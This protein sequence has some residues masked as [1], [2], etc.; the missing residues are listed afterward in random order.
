M[1]E[2]RPGVGG[3][4]RADET[5]VTD[6]LLIPGGPG[7]S[8]FAWTLFLAGFATFA[9]LFAPQAFLSAQL[10]VDADS[11]SMTVSSTALGVAAG[12]LGWAA[13][14]N[15]TGHLR[16][17][18]LSLLVALLVAVVVPLLPDLQSVI[19]VR[20][21]EGLALGAAPAV[22]MAAIAERVDGRWVAHVAGTFVAGNTLGGIVGRLAS[23]AVADV[24]GWRLAFWVSAG[25]AAVA[26]GALLVLSRRLPD[27]RA[28]PA[29]HSAARAVGENLRDPVMLALYLQGF[30]LMGA[31]GAVYNFFGYRVQEPPFGLPA[32]IAGGL[33]LVY[34]TGSVA[35]Q[36]SGALARRIGTA[37]AMVAGIAAML[38]SLPMMA[39]DSLAA[40][41][42]GLV[43]F[44]IGCFTAHPLASGLSGRSA[45]IGRPQSAALYQIAWLGGTSLCGWAG[46]LAYAAAG[47]ATTLGLVAILC[48]VAAVAAVL[49][50]TVLAR[51]RPD[52]VPEG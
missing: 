41:V 45:R 31:F 24:G 49:G 40:M 16:A 27:R 8:V 51:A 25:T 37:R 2:R 39:S 18:R 12:V 44:T 17:I 11:A 47:W 34:L 13:V 26:I 10:A 36:R 19:A 15:R 22:G 23:G 32:W 14:S 52:A 50:G 1:R 6:G 48:A 43:L 29:R 3:G 4:A 5:A 21:V 33:F 42:A 38:V 30:L 35:A 7:W 46:G 9:L 20:F 28:V